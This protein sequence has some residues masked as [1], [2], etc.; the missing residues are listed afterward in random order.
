MIN[1]D[2]NN[3]SPTTINDVDN[4]S[5][6]LKDLSHSSKPLINVLTLCLKDFPPSSYS[7]LVKLLIYHLQTSQHKI[8]TLHLIDSICKAFGPQMIEMF[9][10]EGLAKAFVQAYLSLQVVQEKMEMQK[11]FLTWSPPLF[12]QEYLNTINASLS[13]NKS[14]RRLSA[15]RLD[16]NHQVSSEQKEEK[17]VNNKKTKLVSESNHQHHQ[18]N[19]KSK[20]PSPTAPVS[21]P[22]LDTEELCKILSQITPI[23]LEKKLYSIAKQCANCGLRFQDTEIGRNTLRIHL[24]GHYRRKTRFRQ[25][26][27]RVLARDWF[28]TAE[29]WIQISFSNIVEQ[30][31]VDKSAYFTNLTPTFGQQRNLVKEEESFERIPAGEEAHNTIC[32]ICNEALLA[33]WDDESERWV[34]K[35][36]KYDLQGFPCHSA[37]L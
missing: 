36:A 30:E 14:K 22:F 27:K 9:I 3:N 16:Y 17:T 29:I 28:P 21:S 25:R 33:V 23:T 7:F 37:C 10:R 6:L 5:Y 4:Y 24:D 31:H 1:S 12:S 34:F 11:V 35:G 15:E 26:T 32:S 19:S 18:I 8:P 20:T 2:N 13:K